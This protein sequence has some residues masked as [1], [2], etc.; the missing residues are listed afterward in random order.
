M[1]KPSCALLQA[2]KFFMFLKQFLACIKIASTVE[3]AFFLNSFQHCAPNTTECVFLTHK[4]SLYNTTIKLGA[5]VLTHSYYLILRITCCIL[6]SCLL[7]SFILKHF[8][9]VSWS[10]Q[11]WILLGQLR[12]FPQ[13]GFVWSFLRIRCSLIYFLA[14]VSL[15]KVFT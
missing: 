3:R 9:S 14:G 11:F 8:F 4:D 1:N 13:F 10:W 7:V 5:L 12:D 15:P 2:L 6:L